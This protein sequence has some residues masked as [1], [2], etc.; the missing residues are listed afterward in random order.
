[1]CVPTGTPRPLSPISPRLPQE[2]SRPLRAPRRQPTC[3]RCRFVINV[4][5]ARSASAIFPGSVTGRC[6][7]A[8]CAKAQ[9]VIKHTIAINLP[10]R[11]RSR[12]ISSSQIPADVVKHLGCFHLRSGSYGISGDWRQASWGRIPWTKECVRYLPGVKMVLAEFQLCLC[13]GYR[14]QG[15]DT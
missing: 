9:A 12:Q 14:D 6:D 11:G 3:T 5:P 15:D 10:L 13:D 7:S 4:R 8:F 1:M 2:K